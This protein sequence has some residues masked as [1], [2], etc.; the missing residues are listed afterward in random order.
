MAQLTASLDDMMTALHRADSAGHIE[1]AGKIASMIQ[2][3]YPDHVKAAL[4]MTP[5]MPAPPMNSPPPS[6]MAAF[7]NQMPSRANPVYA[8]APVAGD[9]PP[10]PQNQGQGSQVAPGGGG[11]GPA[12]PAPAGGAPSGGG[13][14]DPTSL[15]GD[16][17]S[18]GNSILRNWVG[19]MPGGNWLAAG[20]S[21][22]Q[23]PVATALN[24]ALPGAGAAAN[25]LGGAL[26][27][28][29]AAAAA[30]ASID[31]QQAAASQQAPVGAVIGNMIGTG[32]TLGAG[33]GALGAGAK[34][35]AATGA[36]VLAPL[37]SGALRAIA[38]LGDTTGA[39]FFA[40]TGKMAATGAVGGAGQTA[41]DVASGH[42][43]LK[44]VIPS[45]LTNMTIGGLAGGTLGQAA[46]KGWEVMAGKLQG[47]MRSGVLDGTDE[48]ANFLYH[49]MKVDP[50]ALAATSQQMAVANGGVVPPVKDVL[51]AYARAEVSK[52]AGRNANLGNVLT[53]AADK[54]TADTAIAVPRALHE[55]SALTPTNDLSPTGSAGLQSIG[56][57]EAARDDAMNTAMRSGPAPLANQRVTLSPG[58]E[59][60]LMHPN[61]ASAMR[62]ATQQQ[63]QQYGAAINSLQANQPSSI[64]I[65]LLDKIRQGVGNQFGTDK[66]A[67]DAAAE[68][69]QGVKTLTDRNQAYTDALGT[70]ANHQAFIEGFKHGQTG[71]TIED[72]SGA[73]NLAANPDTG[74]AYQLGHGS[75]LVSGL[76]DQAVAGPS[77]AKAAMTALAN[78]KTM[79][80]IASVHG[81]PAADALSG[82]IDALNTS[83]KANAQIAPG[84]PVGAPAAHVNENAAAHA[85]AGFTTGNHHAG[86]SNLIRLAIDNLGIGGGRMS[87]AG[88]SRLADMLLGNQPQQVIN[89]LR[90]K[91]V[92][93][94]N[95][96]ILRAYAAAA[97]GATA[98]KALGQ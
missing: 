46:A 43:D 88:A 13:T 87:P 28:N 14:P 58:D 79:D 39:G 70:Y 48:A 20:A 16:L 84:A 31:A 29:P 41:A 92:S 5:P 7:I 98:P 65:D 33:G 73:S 4:N 21:P 51:D 8:P 82:R 64:S 94:G 32:V 47:M 25:A 3:T 77:G 59:A 57:L 23:G 78:P 81:Q 44:D 91:G 56:D 30:K 75:G 72:I 40:R 68:A 24:A 17:V 95:L 2:S 38:A 42:T 1:D 60:V 11:S 53:A 83:L 37:A 54:Q 52:A 27:L 15:G 71:N 10:V 90:A 85:I 96:A 6:A 74:A 97:T 86:S 26:G 35:L 93:E 45:L 61:V 62:R 67:N 34:A 50:D 9:G 66:L 76:A 63:Q 89:L 55:A 80:A 69:M 49:K 18:F 19:S 22:G 12:A 36:P